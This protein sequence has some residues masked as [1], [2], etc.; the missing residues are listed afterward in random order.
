MWS[1]IVA[2]TFLPFCLFLILV[3]TKL[4]GIIKKRKRENFRKKKKQPDET[5]FLGIIM[6]KKRE[7]FRKNK[8]KQ[9]DERQRIRIGPLALSLTS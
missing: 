9:P 6:K 4:L 7:N 1:F 5:K 8:K 2:T 3:K